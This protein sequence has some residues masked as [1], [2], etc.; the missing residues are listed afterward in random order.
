MSNA[1]PCPKWLV[2]PK[3]IIVA[4]IDI[5]SSSGILSHLQA[6]GELAEFAGV[7]EEI[8]AYFWERQSGD[9]PY[10]HFVQKK[11]TM[12]YHKFMGDGWILFFPPETTPGELLN[13]L[14][15]T[16]LRFG[17]RCETSMNDFPKDSMRRRF[18]LRFGVSR[19]EL[20][21]F[22]IRAS[23]EF[24]GGAIVIATRLQESAKLFETF[25]CDPLIVA[26]SC[27]E[28]EKWRVADS[29][30]SRYQPMRKTL[31]IRDSGEIDVEILSLPSNR[32]VFGKA[33]GRGK[34]SSLLRQRS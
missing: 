1:F 10:V 4:V 33:K 20:H 14:H 9:I 6:K 16:L 29:D 30:L 23:A 34:S 28:D 21:R 3:D 15:G 17:S 18:G 31:N 22:N 32:P 13:V 24:L 12:H 19:G 11:I 7:I 27:F 5:H 25:E 26:R 2:D 8:D